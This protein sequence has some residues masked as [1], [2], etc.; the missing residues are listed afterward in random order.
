MRAPGRLLP[1][2]KAVQAGQ[3]GRTVV[4]QVDPTVADQV[5]PVDPVDPSGVD[6]AA[7]ADLTDGSGAHLPP[8]WRG[9]G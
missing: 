4:D 2:S 5:D 7:M 1:G 8:T 9:E 6:R 3:A